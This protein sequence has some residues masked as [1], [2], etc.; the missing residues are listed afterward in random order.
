[1]TRR[2]N[3]TSAAIVPNRLN[4]ICINCSRGNKWRTVEL[5]GSTSWRSQRN[6]SSPQ[7]QLW[8]RSRPYAPEPRRGDIESICDDRLLTNYVARFARFGFDRRADP[9]LALWA[10]NMPPAIR[11]FANIFTALTC[12][13]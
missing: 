10:T 2:H 13:A 9:Q 1:M 5:T 7:R 3:T 4:L 12:S 6:I 11:A 8:V